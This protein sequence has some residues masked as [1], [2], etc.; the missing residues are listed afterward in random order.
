MSGILAISLDGHLVPLTRNQ[1]LTQERA[2]TGKALRL[3]V[4]RVWEQ[5]VELVFIIRTFMYIQC[6]CRHASLVY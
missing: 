1:K 2:D 5:G 3:C 4:E 6:K